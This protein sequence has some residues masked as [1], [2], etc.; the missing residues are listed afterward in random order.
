M[1]GEKREE[2]VINLE[3]DKKEPKMEF[4]TDYPI[5]DLA[6]FIS[7]I[8][9]DKEERRGKVSPEVAEER[10]KY[11][12]EKPNAI[13]LTLEIDGTLVGC[14]FSYE[15][16]RER[17]EKDV[18]YINFFSKKGERVFKIREV[19]VHPDYRRQGFGTI[20]MEE[21]MKR[22]KEKGA[23]KLVLSTFPE[24]ENKANRLYT[25][26]GFREVAP[27]QDEHNYY[28]SYDYGWDK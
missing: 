21:I 16:D 15:E 12:L 22:L 20:V 11:M 3:Q 2:I 13:E 19:D 28:M 17:L 10:I 9:S 26:V 27:D 8:R 7:Y 18:P 23:T 5:K 24:K 1:E 4:K 14:A 25:G 6:K